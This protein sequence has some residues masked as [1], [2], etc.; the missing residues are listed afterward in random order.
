MLSLLIRAYARMQMFSSSMC[1]CR[2]SAGGAPMCSC[3]SLCILSR[4]LCTCVLVHVICAA[5]QLL[6]PCKARVR[7]TQRQSINQSINQS[8]PSPII[9]HLIT[10]CCSRGT[11]VLLA[12]LYVW[13]CCIACIVSCDVLQWTARSCSDFTAMQGSDSGT[14]VW[15]SAI[16]AF[17]GLLSFQCYSQCSF[18]HALP[19][20]EGPLQLRS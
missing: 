11:L 16:L 13:A 10:A 8:S 15:N 18:F 9:P 20:T 6:V 14:R 3:A 19:Q 5:L 1:R 2:C 4:L 12:I 17:Y 7:V